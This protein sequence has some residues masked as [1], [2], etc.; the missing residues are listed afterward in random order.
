MNG[1]QSMMVILV[2]EHNA[3]TCQKQK[4]NFAILLI[5]NTISHMY[6]S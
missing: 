4:A 1:R 6:A 2:K 3:D 5:T